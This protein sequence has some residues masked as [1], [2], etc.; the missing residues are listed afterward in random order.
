MANRFLEFE[1]HDVEK[2]TKAIDRL[3]KEMPRAAAEIVNEA[4]LE[5]SRAVKDAVPVR[6]GRLKSSFGFHEFHY[7]S[8]ATIK[9]KQQGKE[10]AYFEAATP[11]TLTARVGTKL[12]YAPIVHYTHPT[13][14][15]YIYKGFVRLRAHFPKIVRAK[16]NGVAYASTG[17]YSPGTLDRHR[18]N[19]EIYKNSY[20][21]NVR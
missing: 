14:S 13:K 17:R 15:M 7:T 12:P 3:Y 16:L 18:R 1:F 11:Q 9:D 21:G 10:S 4:A 2:M 6:T 8:V 19:I 20:M 5:F